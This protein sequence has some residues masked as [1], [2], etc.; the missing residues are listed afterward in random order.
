MSTDV[1]L[2]RTDC[3]KN[4]LIHIQYTLV[5]M[6]TGDHGNLFALSEIRTNRVRTNCVRINCVGIQINNL[7]SQLPL[8][9]SRI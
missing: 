1:L 5:N 8:Y 4:I 6:N 3:T 2:K 7:Y 9:R